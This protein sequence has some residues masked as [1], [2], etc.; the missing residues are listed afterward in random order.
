MFEA[1]TRRRLELYYR[2]VDVCAACAVCYARIS[3]RRS[4][5]LEALVPPL[6]S[7]FAFLTESSSSIGYS[8]GYRG[9]GGGGGG[10]FGGGSGYGSSISGYGHSGISGSEDT[11]ATQS[12][13]RALMRVSSSLPEICLPGNQRAPRLKADPGRFVTL[14]TA[15][16][17]RI[18]SAATPKAEAAA[19][20]PPQQP[21]L[22]AAINRDLPPP[23]LPNL[24]ARNKHLNKMRQGG[25]IGDSP[26]A[27]PLKGAPRSSSTATLGASTAA[28]VTKSALKVEY[29]VESRVAE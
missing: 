1:K 2:P 29:K 12:L 19:V 24:P 25:Q 5:E 26:Y 3:Q 22:P 9:G 20:A 15:D 7:P 11:G 14:R 28:P 13:S 4:A 6:H 16:G 27:A 10:L 23:M 18:P 21:K 8:G 17:A